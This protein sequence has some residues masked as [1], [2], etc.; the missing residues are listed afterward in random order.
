MG[1]TNQQLVTVMKA[2]P[3]TTNGSLSITVD[4]D[5]PK[6]AIGEPVSISG[7][8]S[9]ESGL[10]N[11]V[12]VSLRV[13]HYSDLSFPVYEASLY[14][15]NSSYSDSSKLKLEEAGKYWIRAIAINNSTSET[16]STSF[17]VY[18]PL[19]SFPAYLMYAVIIPVGVLLGMIMIDVKKGTHIPDI[20]RFACLSCIAL[21]PILSLL[22]AD[23]ELGTS[24]PI[25]LVIKPPYDKNTQQ[26]ITTSTGKSA[27]GGEWVINVGGHRDNFYSTGLQIPVSVIVFGL[28]GSYIRYLYKTAHL[29]IVHKE[30]KKIKEDTLKELK[31]KSIE[32]LKTEHLGI[33]TASLKKYMDENPGLAPN[34]ELAELL[35]AKQMIVIRRRRKFTFYQSLKDIALFILAPLLAIAVWFLLLQSGLTNPYALA[36]ISFTVGL[37][38]E[39][40]MVALRD[41]LGGVLKGIG[42]KIDDQGEIIVNQGKEESSKKQQ[43]DENIEKKTSGV[44]TDAAA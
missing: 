2:Q 8:I 19:T 10:S 6:Y 43:P 38:T 12:K 15:R 20:V 41:F 22:L 4:T 3:S 26:P 23:F 42:E 14:T 39:Q 29:Q 16:A 33:N 17:N 34:S 13:Y 5:H 28:A 40:F 35:A 18:D 21:F 30:L 25:G 1:L 31:G 32:Q 11:G 24:S 9:E 27:P 7:T 36:V 37:F 44:G